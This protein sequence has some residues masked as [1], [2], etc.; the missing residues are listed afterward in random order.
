MSEGRRDLTQ[1]YFQD[2]EMIRRVVT[3]QDGRLYYAEWLNAAL[4]VLIL[5]GT[6]AMGALVSTASFAVSRAALWVWLPLGFLWLAFAVGS[7]VRRL[8]RQPFPLFA[9]RFRKFVL[10]E[11]GVYA[12]VGTLAA[13]VFSAAGPR[14][15]LAL[16]ML[17]PHVMILGFYTVGALHYTGLAMVV[18]G[19]TTAALAPPS[20]AAMI[21]DG[22]VGGGALI[23]TSL[24]L[25]RS[26]IGAGA[27]AGATSL[28]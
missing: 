17:V 14:P 20:A 15:G 16:L 18:I 19:L 22:V 25:F 6:A 13:Q 3:E 28:R 8:L 11:V 1:G 23:I 21:I 9:Q 5:A 12:A 24:Q 27:G 10:T 7:A 4:G 26:G 2:I